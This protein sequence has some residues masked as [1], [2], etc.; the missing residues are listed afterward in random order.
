MTAAL[1][2][3]YYRLHASTLAQVAFGMTT[4]TGT[5][6]GIWMSGGGWLGMAHTF[7]SARATAIF[8]ASSGGAN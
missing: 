7:T 3:G 2:T 5:Q 6:A 4:P 1:F 8:N